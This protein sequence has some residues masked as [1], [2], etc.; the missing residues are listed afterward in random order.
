[1]VILAE[2]RH[3]GRFDGGGGVPYDENRSFVPGRRSL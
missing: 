2:W 1:M 3:G